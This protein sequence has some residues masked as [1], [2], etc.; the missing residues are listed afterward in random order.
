MNTRS[1]PPLDQWQTFLFFRHDDVGNVFF[2]PIKLPYESEVL[3]NVRRNPG[4]IKVTDA[5]GN[6]VWIAA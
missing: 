3:P 5:Q 1:F 4:T 6:V 2:Y